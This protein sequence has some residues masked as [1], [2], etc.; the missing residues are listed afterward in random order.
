MER[1]VMCLF[2]M[3]CTGIPTDLSTLRICDGQCE[4]PNNTINNTAGFLAGSKY[5]QSLKSDMRVGW[6]IDQLLFSQCFLRFLFWIPLVYIFET[7][8]IDMLLHKF[9]PQPAFRCDALQCLAEIAAID[10]RTVDAKYHPRIQKM[11]ADF[12][13]N[14]TNIVPPT[15]VRQFHQQG[16][17]GEEFVQRLTLFLSTILKTHLP[18][19]ETQELLL[20]LMQGLQY[21]VNISEVSL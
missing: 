8:L 20:H 9:F 21:L 15:A 1:F 13:T 2:E 3:G 5:L 18:I 16:D 4:K 11:Y 19:L 6:R 17:A 14:L 7:A 12:I 10:P